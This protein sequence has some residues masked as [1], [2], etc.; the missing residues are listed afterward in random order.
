MSIPSI[1]S[2]F[3]DE[4]ARRILKSVNFKEFI[5]KA[6][7]GK[8]EYTRSELSIILGFDKPL[9]FVEVA[10]FITVLE[11]LMIF[12][13]VQ[14]RYRCKFILSNIEKLLELEKAY[15]PSTSEKVYSPFI[16]E[17]EEGGQGFKVCERC[18]ET[19]KFEHYKQTNEISK[20]SICGTEDLLYQ[21]GV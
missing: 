8:T 4:I 9:S 21:I 3:D 13:R 2:S 11:N 16:S 12:A 10:R 1:N 18:K 6:Q 14:N 5:R 17:N 15:A 7:S 20:C 19:Y